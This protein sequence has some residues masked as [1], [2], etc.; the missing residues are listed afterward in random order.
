[1]SAIESLR[2]NSIAFSG[3]SV[4]RRLA[5]NPIIGLALS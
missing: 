2:F 3:Q 4:L 5:R 1:M